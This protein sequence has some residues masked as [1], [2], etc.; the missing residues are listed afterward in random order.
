MAAKGTVR[1]QEA[2]RS[3]FVPFLSVGSIELPP[4]VIVLILAFAATW[5]DES[6]ALPQLA[7]NSIK[8]KDKHTKMLFFIHT[9]PAQYSKL[10][11]HVSSRLL[12][13]ILF[14]AN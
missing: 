4:M 2:V 8:T 14:N 1:L 11:Y 10:V 12:K 6:V 9:T 3:P 7:T 13:W 5:V